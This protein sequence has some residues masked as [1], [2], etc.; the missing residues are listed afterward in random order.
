[1]STGRLTERTAVDGQRYQAE[2][3]STHG[4]EDRS[5]PHDPR[6]KERFL[7]GFSFFVHLLD[8]IEK[9]DDGLTIT[10]I[11]LAT[12]AKAPPFYSRVYMSSSF[13]FDLDL[14][15]SSFMSKGLYSNLLNISR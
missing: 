1:M 6:A 10:P 15:S 8:E 14:I 7:E 3:R 5:E 11:R 13:D 4:D 12:P 2:D 9:H